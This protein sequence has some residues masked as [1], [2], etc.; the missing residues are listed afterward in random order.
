MFR[1]AFWLFVVT[2]AVL[3][4][5]GLMTNIA[6]LTTAA[7]A[8]QTRKLQTVAGTDDF[9]PASSFEFSN[10][11]P[12][13]INDNTI[14]DPYPSVITVSNVPGTVQKITVTLN[15][16]Q[17]SFPDDVD[18]LLVAPNG[19]S[20]VLMSD[21]GGS[22]N[23]SG[24]VLTFDDAA[25][26]ALPDNGQIT[27]GTFKPTDFEP[28]DDFP[29]PA[30]PAPRNSTLAAFNGINPNGNWRLFAVD[31][32]GQDAGII[33]SGWSLSVSNGIT[34][35]NQT[36]INIPDSGV[37]SL[38]P[39]TI[40]VTGL[41]GSVTNVR[42]FLNNLTHTAPDDID[43]LLVAPNGR[44]VILMSDVGG[45]LAVNDVSLILDDAAATSLPDN[46]QIASGAFKPTNIGGGDFFPQPAPSD[47]PTAPALAGFNG[48]N[49]NGTWSLYLV[50]AAGGN[51]GTLSGGWSLAINTSTTACPLTIAPDIQSFSHTGG[52]GSF[53]V[54]SPA[55]CAWTATAA[56][57]SFLTV[58]SNQTGAGNGTINFTVPA[59]FGGARTGS[60][61]VSNNTVTRSF[62]AQQASGCPFALG[63]E[64][65]N[66]PVGGGAGNV[67]VTA[68]RGCFWQVTS[69]VGW[70]TIDSAAGGILGSSIVTF[71]VAPNG[72]NAART[73]TITIGARTLT[74]TQD[75]GTACPYTLSKNSD[76][77]AAT[78]GAGSFEVLAASVCVWTVTS[79]VGWVT[80]N[81]AGGSGNATVNFTVAP[82][83]SNASRSGTITVNGQIFNVAQ[84]RGGIAPPFDF[85]GDNKTDVAVFRPSNGVWY[86][87][88]SADNSASAVQFGIATD[89]L[90]AADYDGDRRADIAVFRNGIWYILNS[91][92][93]V[94]R[95]LQWGQAGDVAVPGD[96]DG[97]NQADVAVFRPSTATW[98]V[99]RSLD[100]GFFAQQFGARSDRPVPA[101][102]D[103]DGKF[104]F[105]LYRAG[106]TAGSPSIWFERASSNN[107]LITFQ[108]GVGEDVPVPAD[109]DGDGRA[110][111]ALFRPSSATWF[112]STDPSRNF[113]YQ[114][115][116]LADDAL[117]PG[118]YDGD[119]KID[120]AVFRNGVWYI[121]QTSNGTLRTQVW[122]VASDLPVAS[123]FK[124]AV[125]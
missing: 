63:A 122:G 40:N 82:N 22:R 34:A 92:N 10:S 62:T 90:V 58:T 86:V 27:S 121:L 51:A 102:Y 70:I 6:S 94:F 120:V 2:A 87:L 83:A 118:D 71:S 101:D 8:A 84:G 31:D 104:D 50:D 95:S 123:P 1:T 4:G 105:A 72:T 107:R 54:F 65:Q 43:V 29:P 68:A 114:P 17:H 124:P 75:A 23:T 117:A 74:V 79:N 119:G 18:V 30:P 109:Y 88:R 52:A 25:Q 93:N 37:G 69:G 97:D 59:N 78:G 47:A 45:N 26:N 15:D 103:G 20:I 49:P 73:G 32:T 108:F 89:R 12:V 100:G 28:G 11:N 85:D 57:F 35:Q 98:Y 56:A 46:G 91:S 96:Y 3:F 64:T 116:G 9:T 80:V 39:S 53:A 33:A 13:V 42:V 66:F 61:E 60:I 125:P 5:I 14:A 16:F 115:W 77:A 48:I 99:L 110:G 111:F 67:G 24:A 7:S 38:Y 19:Q 113:D 44:S 21:A 55:G 41:T 76:Y 106:A 112:R 36:P 81:P